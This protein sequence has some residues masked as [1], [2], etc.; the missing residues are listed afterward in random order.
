MNIWYV[1]FVKLPNSDEAQPVALFR[2]EDN[3]LG[4]VKIMYES[5]KAQVKPVALS[6]VTMRP[7]TFGDQVTL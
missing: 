1:V 3:A 5:G 7:I 2:F 4:W 6:N